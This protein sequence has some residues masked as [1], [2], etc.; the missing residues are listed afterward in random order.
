MKKF[1]LLL[2]ILLVGACATYKPK[3]DDVFDGQSIE[4]DGELSHRFYLI[5]DAGLS[6]K[7]DM[8]PTLK[9]LKSRLD[10]AHENSTTIFLGDNIYPTGLPSKKEDQE[11]HAVAKNHLDAQL[12]VLS[13]YKGKP[14]FIPGNH[15]WY[16]KGLDGLK[17]QEKYIEKA[18]DNKA[19]FFPANGCP[20][21]EIEIND[22][23][24][25]IAIDTEWY[26]T[27]WDK[28]P[29]INDDC[30]IQD[31]EGFFLELEDVIKDNAKKTTILV[32]HH[33][34]TSYGPH[35][36]QYSFKKNIYP[37]GGKFPLPFLGT[38]I[39][40]LRKTTGASIADI[41]NKRYNT[42]INRVL[43]LAQYSEKVI[44][45]SGH[46][47]SLQ[48]IVEKNTP[49]IVSGSGAKKGATRLLNGS[50]FSSGQMGYAVLD[51]YKDGSSKV[52]FFG[53]EGE[54]ESLLYSTTVLQ[55]P[56]K[57]AMRVF[58]DSFPHHVEA[59]VYTDEEV[60]KTGFFKTVWGERYRKYYATK[61]KAQTVTLDTLLGGLIPVRKGG[62]H[63]SKSLRLVH[64]DGRQFV[65]RALKKS[66]ELYL[67]SL[68]FKE[69]Y[70]VGEFEG[71]LTEDILKDFYTGAHPYAPFTIGE[72]SDAVSIYHTNPKLYYV[73]KHEAL[74][75]FNED[76]G[77]ELYMIEEHVSE[78]H[79]INSFGKAKKIE[80][81]TNLMKKLRKDEAYKVDATVYARARLFDMLI[82]D[83]DRHVDQ[84]RW[85]QFKD[86]NGDKIFRPIPRDRDQAF[87]IMGDGALMGFATRAIPALRLFEGFKEEIRSVKGYN[88]S[89]LTF[90]LDM[91]LLSETTAEIWVQQAKYI[92]EHLTEDAV[93]SAFANFPAEVRDETITGMKQVLL[94]RKSNLVQTAKT[95]YAILNK[96]SV[97]TGTDKDDYFVINTLD[98]GSLD[99]KVYRI[100]NGKKTDLFFD[101]IYD[102]TLTKEIWLYGLD[103]DDVFEVIGTTGKIK[104]RLVGGHNNDN[105][106]ISE[107][108]KG[109]HVYDFKDKKNT[110]AEA[111]GGRV[112]KI[113]DYDTNNFQFL[114]IKAS[115]NQ[116][117]PA[118][119][120]N[121]DDGFRIGF[122]NIYTF[123]GFRQNPFTQQHTLSGA[124]YF[125]TNGFDL[126][127]TGEFANVFE[128][129]NLELGAKFTSPNFSLNF[130]GFGNDTENFDDE[131]PLELDF[132]R[133]KIRTL[134]FSPALIW[135]GQLGSKVRVGA[136]YENYDVEETEGRFIEGFFTNMNRDT[137]Q[138]F[139]GVETEYS[140]TNTDNAAFPTM[141][142][143]FSLTGGFKTNLSEIGRNFGYL[144]PSLSFDHRITPNGRLVFATKLKGHFN[145]GN[146]FE[147]YQAADIG[148]NNG[149][150]GFRFQRFIGKTA[151]YQN[152][153]IRYSF[154]KTR[155]GLLPVTPGIFGGFDYGRVWLPN[156]D[157]NIWHNSYGG[158]LFVNGSDLIS[159]NLGVF[160]STDGLRV[161]FGVGFGF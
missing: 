86:E 87:S 151:Y 112:H 148:A 68:A 69:E 74:G 130:F 123:N 41:Q 65:M 149:L 106:K 152:T 75:G 122:S 104:L 54:N 73:P 100:K 8:N 128:N 19:V 70:V 155:T 115:N 158:G 81:T 140:Y 67:Q 82:G 17:R 46:E 127:Y 49:Q 111:Y 33:P 50:M 92:Q 56:K 80:S 2:S 102:P 113:R 7:N 79:D 36:G 64:K 129:V 154:R 35:G 37:S 15:D 38:F 45:A 28:H 88:S 110:Y 101:K 14:I 91:A 9:A 117:L 16:A 125:A 118:I 138:D 62:G 76:F 109:V 153:D 40:L 103:D 52:D 25:V 10:K 11:G 114:K 21:E 135:R 96:Y 142:M 39:N 131:N 145:I 124:Y 137:Q 107:T 4:K 18:L 47:H 43:T 97:V 119:G 144:I 44:L 1:Y 120:A 24:T 136:S 71:T 29:D 156:E 42:L 30:E 58:S 83:W 141:G 132:N 78:G 159:A 72:L 32:T 116:L 93:D 6:P 59:S 150:R 34:M 60:D 53:V 3:Y 95:Y 161:A 5:G 51:V 121:P 77:D 99:V 126:A 94:A 139:F 13:D 146:D 89:P 133:V 134:K 63:Q 20:I 147:F 84:W 26:L 27:N 23:V 22:E 61:V 31:R 157:S 85:A 12:N 90:A 66:A 98:N 48:Y 105:Y 57:E 55:A 108:A 143:A 160:N